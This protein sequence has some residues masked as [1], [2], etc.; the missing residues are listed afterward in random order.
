[1]R[2]ALCFFDATVTVWSWLPL[3]PPPPHPPTPTPARAPHLFIITHSRWYIFLT[4]LA[5]FFV[6]QLVI[7]GHRERN[8]CIPPAP[9]PVAATGCRE[10]M[11]SRK[12]FRS[13]RIEWSKLSW[14]DE[15]N[16][17][18]ACQHKTLKNTKKGIWKT[19]N[20]CFISS[21]SAWSPWMQRRL[22]QH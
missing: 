4:F 11:V 16:V 17:R 22:Q 7:G 19:N 6:D 21:E 13:C 9:P 8:S 20:T 18:Q 15:C 2:N 14:M 1:M 12:S 3:S 5:F 10:R